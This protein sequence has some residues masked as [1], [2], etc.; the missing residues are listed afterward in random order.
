MYF[1]FRALEFM[2]PQTETVCRTLLCHHRFKQQPQTPA[3]VNGAGSF[4]G[5]SPGQTTQVALASVAL[6]RRDWC[7]GVGLC[8]WKRCWI[9]TSLFWAL[10]TL[11]WC[12]KMCALKN[13]MQVSPKASLVHFVLYDLYHEEF[14]VWNVLYIDKGYFGLQTF[15]D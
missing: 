2:G 13:A 7:G 5:E 14:S 12:T 9:K 4:Q 6:T 3:E 15:C 11:R 10:P 1:K 8:I